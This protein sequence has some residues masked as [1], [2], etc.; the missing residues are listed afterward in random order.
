[1]LVCL[2]ADIAGAVLGGHGTSGG[3]ARGCHGGTVRARARSAGARL[4]RLLAVQGSAEARRDCV[5]QV[6]PS[7]RLLPAARRHAL[8]QSRQRCRDLRPTF[9]QHRGNISHHTKYLISFSFS[10]AER[11]HLRCLQINA[12][13]Q[14][15][16]A[17]ASTSR[18]SMPTSVQTQARAAPAPA[19]PEDD[20]D[21]ELYKESGSIHRQRDEKL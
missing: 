17:V 14:D 16:Q 3:G 5:E 18:A 20:V 7:E 2:C 15:D 1:M 12:T 19:P 9:Y 13:P 4:L 8:P 10:L 11:V 6:S 21:L